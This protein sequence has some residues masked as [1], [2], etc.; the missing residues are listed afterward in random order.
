MPLRHAPT[1]PSP[2]A[3]YLFGRHLAENAGWVH[4]LE[5]W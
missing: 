5:G 1:E 3:A 4:Y 2:T